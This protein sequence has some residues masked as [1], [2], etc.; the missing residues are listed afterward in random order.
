VVYNFA[1]IRYYS[2][3]SYNGAPAMPAHF[4]TSFNSKAFIK[5]V[6]YN[7][8]AALLSS[9]TSEHQ[10]LMC[11]STCAGALARIAQNAA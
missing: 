10:T 5:R 4:L 9:N 8:P 1:R 7:L 6:P 2:R 11:A 3:P